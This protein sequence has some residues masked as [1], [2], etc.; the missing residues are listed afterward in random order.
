MKVVDLGE[1]EITGQCELENVRAAWAYWQNSRQWS[2]TR[3]ANRVVLIEGQSDRLPY[4]DESIEKWLEG[5]SGS[6]RGFELVSDRVTQRVKVLVFTDPLCTRPVYYLICDE[7]VCISDKLST[8]VLNSA[9]VAKPDWGGLL[10][11]AVLGSLYSHKTTVKD[12]V[13]LA[14]G[15]AVEFEGRELIRRWKNA[16]PADESLTSNEVMAHPAETLQFAIEKAIRETWTD[17]EM[18]LLLSGGLDSRI[19]LALASGERKTITLEL[20]SSETQVARQVA[21]AA[22]ADLEV[23]PAPDYEFPIRWAYLVTGA[24]HDSKFVTHL[25]L[26]Q[27]WRK[28]GIGG[29]THGYFHNTMYRGWTAAPFVRYPNQSSILFEWMGR[30]AYYFDKYGCKPSTLPRQFYGLLSEDGKAVLRRQLRELSDSMVPVMRDGYDLTFERRLMEFVPR[31]IYF[32]IMLGWYEGV[33]VA[34]P[35]FQP[36]LW[37]WYGLSHP[38]HRER[39]WA[40]RE[41]FLALDHAAAKLPDSNTGKPIAHLK[42]DWRDGVRNQFWYPGFR[43]VYQ[44]LFWKPGPYE[45]VGMSWGSRLREAKVLSALED[46]VSVVRDNFLFDAAR[47]QTAMD[48]YRGGENQ[49][50]DAICALT[51]I[52]QWQRLI[53]YPELQTAQVRVFEAGKSM[54]TA[55]NEMSK[56]SHQ[57]HSLGESARV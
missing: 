17:P 1:S 27:D 35:V 32:C 49:L 26:V 39:D 6:F 7:C 42:A 21:A 46:G 45:E 34:S 19:L 44:K 2:I 38:R 20:Y 52:G 30:N 25:G 50:V 4:P 51:A 31:Q 8:V 33:D 47:V 55:R 29:I 15:E 18:R 36:A 24:M 41:I 40:I 16:L 57:V 22:G 37:T 11:A 28:R 23:V 12:A 5:R 14:P 9:G 10:E 48:A 56:T 43:A 3:S 53:S 13:W 54:A